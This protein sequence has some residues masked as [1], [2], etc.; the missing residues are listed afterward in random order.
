[1]K[2][3]YS[4]LSRIGH[5]ISPLLDLR[6]CVCSLPV[7]MLSGEDAGG[8]A[9]C[10]KTALSDDGVALLEV[11]HPNVYNIPCHQGLCQASS[12]SHPNTLVVF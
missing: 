1:M 8:L 4:L 9:P 11:S 10:N 3:G 12:L 7:P 6:F 5:A 2:Q